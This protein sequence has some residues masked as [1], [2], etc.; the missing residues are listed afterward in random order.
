MR[1]C[2]AFPSV[3]DPLDAQNMSF[4][5]VKPGFT[6]LGYLGEVLLVMKCI[7]VFELLVRESHEFSSS[8]CRV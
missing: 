4:A 7:P 2:S 3:L 5:P 6:F 8:Q 1:T